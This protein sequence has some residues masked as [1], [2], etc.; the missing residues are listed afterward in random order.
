M[1]YCIFVLYA[2]IVVTVKFY[3]APRLLNWHF[4]IFVEKAGKIVCFKK[5]ITLRNG[6]HYAHS[7]RKSV[8]DCARIDKE[9]P[10][11]KNF[12]VSCFGSRLFYS[13]MPCIRAALKMPP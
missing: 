12:A 4:S 9:E 5:D 11:K 8:P 6:A 3:M 7:S 1:M 13:A 10:K 2:T